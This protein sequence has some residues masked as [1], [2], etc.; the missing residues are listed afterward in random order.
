LHALTISDKLLNSLQAISLIKTNKLKFELE[1]SES[2][3]EDSSELS[4]SSEDE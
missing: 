3:S 1:K 4:A 2:D